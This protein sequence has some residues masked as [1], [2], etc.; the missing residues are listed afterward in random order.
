L[1]SSMSTLIDLLYHFASQQQDLNISLTVS[2]LPL[3]LILL[4]CH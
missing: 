3:V 2:L 4:R 1:K